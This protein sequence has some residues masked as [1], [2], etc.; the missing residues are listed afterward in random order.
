MFKGYTETIEELKPIKLEKRVETPDELA[1]VVAATA[2]VVQQMLRLFPGVDVTWDAAFHRAET[3]NTFLGQVREGY[4][5]L[6]FQA[7]RNDK[8]NEIGELPLDAYVVDNSPVRPWLLA[9][10]KGADFILDFLPDRTIVASAD[11]PEYVAM[12]DASWPEVG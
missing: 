6:A 5:D 10:W 2:Q 4:F 1:R 8:A 3:A 12:L 9:T 11:D 7:M